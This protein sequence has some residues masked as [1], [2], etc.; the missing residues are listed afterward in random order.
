MKLLEYKLFLFTFF[1]FFVYSRPIPRGRR[2]ELEGF[3][4]FGGM[5]CFSLDQ[6]IPWEKENAVLMKGLKPFQKRLLVKTR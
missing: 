5:T 6:E 1:A 3:F 4:S 2:W